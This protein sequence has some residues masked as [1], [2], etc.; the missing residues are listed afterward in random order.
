FPRVEVGPDNPLRVEKDS[1]AT[2]QCAVDAK[3]KVTAVRW[4]RNNRYISSSHNH[5]IHRV[6]I[7]DA[8]RYTCSAD[9]GL[10]KIG[11]KDIVLDVLY[12]PMV[13]LEAKTKEAEEGESVFIKCNVTA[14][15]NPVTVEWV[16]E[17]KPDFSHVTAEN[18]GTYVCRAVN[19][20]NPSSLPQRPTEKI[21]NASIALLIRHKPGRARVMPDKP[22]ATEGSAVTLTC[23]ATPP[24]WPAPQYRWFRI[25]SD[26]QTT[27]L[28]TGTKYT[29]NNANLGTE[30]VYNCQA[31]NE[32]GPGEMAS[33]E[34]EVHQ[35]PSFKYKLKPLETK[36]VGEPNFSVACSAKGKPRPMVKWLKDDEELTADANMYE[37]K[38]DYA[39][40]GNGAVNVQTVLKFSGKARPNGNELLPSDRGVYACVFEN[41]VKSKV[42]YDLGETA[43]VVCKVQAYPKPEFKWFF[44]N[45]MSPLHSSSEGHYVVHT[46]SDDNDIYTSILR[47]SNI[48]K[49]DYGE[50]NCQIVNSRGKI[51]TKIRLQSKGPPEKPTKLV[52]LHTGPNFVT[53]GWEL[54]FNG[55]IANTKYFVQYKK[56]TSDNDVIVEGCGTIFKPTE[57]TE[58]DCHQN[59]PC[60]ITHLEQHQ[61]YLFKVPARQ[62]KKSAPEPGWTASLCPNELLTIELPIL[63][64]STFL[65]LVCL[66]S[67]LWKLSVSG[68]VP[69]YKE[70]NL[71]QI[72]SRGYQRSLVD[73]PIGVNDEENPR[74]RVKLCL[75]THPEHCGEFIEAEMGYAHIREASALTTPTLIAIVV[76]CIVF[77]L[78]VGLLLVFCRCK[79]NQSKKSQQA[80]DY[81]M[82][83]VRPTIVPQQNQAPPPYYP[84]TGMENKALEHSLDLALAMEDQKSV[85]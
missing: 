65:P 68:L 62:A 52:A 85:V 59:V 22:V 77:L 31:T 28:A 17:G 71:D 9:N 33:V 8:G 64:L 58:V 72:T 15:P 60:N 19:L 25:G 45:N 7:Q 21:G 13:N 44:S 23:T 2:L 66:S 70:K 42:A 5:I 46:T 67:P 43:E 48:K 10:G 74:V 40:G 69:T 51:E 83:S 26:G 27:I 50:Y 75:Q 73:E 57:W 61:S 1:Q 63:C 35:P 18:S 79:R 54:G 24:G 3:P 12:G 11:E 36:R 84:S 39:E 37:V 30:G 16:K 34:L 47:I 49:Q 56:V 41:E 4:T 38:T 20:I 29:I 53:L 76:S 6:S 14:N 82:D 32:L 80:K 81:E 55:G 78:F